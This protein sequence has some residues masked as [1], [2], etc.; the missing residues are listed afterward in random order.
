M[1]LYSILNR[2]DIKVAQVFQKLTV[3]VDKEKLDKVVTII[4]ALEK[5]G[6]SLERAMA[7]ALETYKLSGAV[8]AGID[9]V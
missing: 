5:T 9:N 7:D 2:A 1:S 8:N 4:E 3:G 6:K